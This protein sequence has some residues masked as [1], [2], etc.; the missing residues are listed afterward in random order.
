MK[1]S[2]EQLQEMLSKEIEK[3]GKGFYSDRRKTLE[4][5]LRVRG[6]SLINK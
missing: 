1:Y 3:N 4:E 2:N 6:A 5:M